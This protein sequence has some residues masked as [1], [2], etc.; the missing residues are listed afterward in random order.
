MTE[1]QAS[2]WAVTGEEAGFGVCH[3]LGSF[4]L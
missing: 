2:C 3:G 1:V 4:Q